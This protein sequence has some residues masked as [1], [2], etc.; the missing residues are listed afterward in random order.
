[1]HCW[2]RANRIQVVLFKTTYASQHQDARLSRGIMCRNDAFA[3]GE[4]GA[5]LHHLDQPAVIPHVAQ[6]EG[7]RLPLEV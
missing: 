5:L 1:M 2:P 7:R 4:R 6:S 3:L